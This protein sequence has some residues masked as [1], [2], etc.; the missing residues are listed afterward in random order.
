MDELDLA[1]LAVKKAAVRL[2]ELLNKEIL[3]NSSL[4]KDIKLQAD[5]EAENIIC[6]HISDHSSYLILSEELTDKIDYRT[7]D[8]IWIIDPLDGSLN[9]LRGIPFYCISVGLWKNGRPILGVIYDLISNRMYSGKIEGNAFCDNHKI[10][11]SIIIK[12]NEAIIST[13]FPVYSS[14]DTNSLTSFVN[15]IQEYKKVRLLGSAALSITLVATGS[16][17]AYSEN[18][19]AIWDVAGALA[20]LLAAGGSYKLTQGSDLN[21]VNVY[22][23]NGKLK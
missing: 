19:I 5:K 16:I 8:Y 1:K 23:T 22:A 20:I 2:H 13:G 12:K 3:V 15:T 11:A 4:G 6:N 9:Y 14:F 17:D 7:K 18:N 10:F 21:L